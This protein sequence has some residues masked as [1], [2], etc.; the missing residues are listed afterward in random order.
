MPYRKVGYAEQCF[1][2]VKYSI[3]ERIKAIKRY[4][5]KR[6]IEKAMGFRLKEWQ[7]RY[8]FGDGVYMPPGRAQG[9]TTAFLIKLCITPGDPITIKSNRIDPQYIDNQFGALYC[10]FYISMLK[11]THTKLKNAG[12]KV[13]QIDFIKPNMKAEGRKNGK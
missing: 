2:I 13:R 1:Y 4:G 12:V 8:I 5:T 9:C 11:T 10:N 3:R 7:T 6:K